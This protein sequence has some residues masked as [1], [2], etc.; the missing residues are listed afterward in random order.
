MQEQLQ[1]A[2]QLA[3][4]KIEAEIGLLNQLNSMQAQMQVCAVDQSAVFSTNVSSVNDRAQIFRDD[5]TITM[6]PDGRVY[7]H[8]TTSSG[9][10]LLGSLMVGKHPVAHAV[11]I[12][13][14]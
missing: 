11:P 14:N 6:F 5:A 7:T 1:K 2:T 10:H 13:C 12:N 9:Q 4:E 3:N 8:S